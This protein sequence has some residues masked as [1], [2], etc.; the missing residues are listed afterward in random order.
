M[1]PVLIRRALTAAVFTSMPIAQAGQITVDS[2]TTYGS[3]ASTYAGSTFTLQSQVSTLDA[4]NP[5]SL[6]SADRSH[7][8]VNKF[9]INPSLAIALGSQGQLTL[10]NFIDEVH[11]QQADSLFEVD[12]TNF[13]AIQ[14]TLVEPAISAVPLPASTWLFVMGLLGLVGSR[15]HFGRKPSTEPTGQMASVA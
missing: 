7:E 3:S 1:F 11:A 10:W 15:L 2:V 4:L 9:Q 8:S 12:R 6:I 13:A 5:T 14:E